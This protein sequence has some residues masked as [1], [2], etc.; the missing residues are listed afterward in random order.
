MYRETLIH[1]HKF[2]LLD[3]ITNLLK[4]CDTRVAEHVPHLFYGLVNSIIHSLRPSHLFLHTNFKRT[5]PGREVKVGTLL[6]FGGFL[7]TLHKPSSKGENIVHVCKEGGWGSEQPHL[8]LQR[9]KDILE[10][11]SRRSYGS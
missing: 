11:G 2:P 9:S 8:E 1:G 3:E 5:I 6:V 4:A 10:S 7:S